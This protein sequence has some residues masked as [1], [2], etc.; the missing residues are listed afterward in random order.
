MQQQTI[1]CPY[2]DTTIPLDK[3]TDASKDKFITDMLEMEH[4]STIEVLNYDIECPLCLKSI[5]IL[6][7]SISHG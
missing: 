1:N 5:D 4:S 3:I 7:H 2:C 6:K